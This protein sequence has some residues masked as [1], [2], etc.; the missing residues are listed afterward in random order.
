M[1]AGCVR[2]LM[3][4]CS[5]TKSS[6]GLLANSQ[7]VACLSYERDSP[8]G[9]AEVPAI[10]DGVNAVASMVAIRLLHQRK[11]REP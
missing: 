9:F 7:L 6:P 5:D 10:G 3:V 8:L 2:W 1:I 11:V 4:S